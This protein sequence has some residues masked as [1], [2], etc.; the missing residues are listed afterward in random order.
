MSHVGSASA[1]DIFSMN[2]I[3]WLTEIFSGCYGSVVSCESGID[4]FCRPPAESGGE[5][6]DPD[7]PGINWA[8]EW[9]TDGANKPTNNTVSPVIK[10]ASY[11]QIG[12][13][14]N[15]YQLRRFYTNLAL[16]SLSSFLFLINSCFPVWPHWR[17]VWKKVR[18]KLL[19]G[20][21]LSSAGRPL[22]WWVG[23]G[24]VGA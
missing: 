6:G 11:S 16:V 4:I 3:F 13:K 12:S 22:W 9:R 2:E 23:V 21:I 20:V 17:N 8:S 5:E 24:G 18:V 15:I 19:I 14:L 10:E 1:D 7:S